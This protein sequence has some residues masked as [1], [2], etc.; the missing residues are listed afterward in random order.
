MTLRNEKLSVTGVA[1][2]EIVDISTWVNEKYL[3]ETLEAL[4]SN[5]HRQYVISVS[6]DN[7]KMVGGITTV[8]NV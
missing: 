4:E 5:E 3:N 7:Y 8:V 6:L 1:T 2:G